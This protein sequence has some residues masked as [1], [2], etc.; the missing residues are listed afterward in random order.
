MAWR[1]TEYAGCP[2]LTDW[3]DKQFKF[4]IVLDE[5]VTDIKP[6]FVETP[7]KVYETLEIKTNSI[8][9]PRFYMRI[10]ENKS[11]ILNY[12]F[13]LLKGLER[14]LWTLDQN[15]TIIRNF[16]G[17]YHT[18][19]TKQIDT[20]EFEDFM[21]IGKYAVDRFPKIAE[22]ITQS[23]YL[24]Q[25]DVPED[26]IELIEKYFDKIEQLP[27]LDLTQRDLSRDFYNIILV[28]FEFEISSKGL[29][30]RKNT[31]SKDQVQELKKLVEPLNKF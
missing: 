15:L 3:I 31:F 26:E 1:Y 7:D 22:E 19:T 27:S 8:L 30:P 25:N 28:Y 16:P 24:F 4:G 5:D 12:E 20:G 29:I 21:R 17:E 10:G 9:R 2:Q 23:P 11:S 18:L 14:R 6:K 13:D